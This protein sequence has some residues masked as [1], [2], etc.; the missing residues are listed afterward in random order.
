MLSKVWDTV[1]RN[2][3]AKRK[4]I[5]RIGESDAIAAERRGFSRSG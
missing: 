2:A 3:S 4:G 5:S 1:I